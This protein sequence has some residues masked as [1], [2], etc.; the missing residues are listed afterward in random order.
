MK[1]PTHKSY[2]IASLFTL[3]AIF[4]DQLSK[5]L[6]VEYLKPIRS[7]SLI[8]GVFSLHYLENRGAAFGILYGNQVFLITMSILVTSV[9][10]YFYGRIPQTKRHFYIRIVAVLIVSGA[11]GNLIDRI[12]L[13]FV[14]DFFFF[15]LI[16]FPIFNIADSL[17][18]IAA[19]LLLTLSIFY[20][21]E[22]EL[23]FLFSFSGNKEKDDKAIGEKEIDEKSNVEE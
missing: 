15:E 22:E 11:I 14:I 3:F 13:G 10:I 20:Y 19:I 12:R 23:E 16:N 4:L 8:E 21:K 6:A 7:F 2:L 9:I 5:W 1:N 18:V 17:I